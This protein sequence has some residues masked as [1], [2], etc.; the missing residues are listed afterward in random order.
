MIV[1]VKQVLDTIE[2][3]VNHKTNTLIREGV[4]SVINPFVT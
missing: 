3:S 4:E 2:V 1:C